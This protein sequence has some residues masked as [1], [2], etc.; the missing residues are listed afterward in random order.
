VDIGLFVFVPFG[1]VMISVDANRDVADADAI[2]DDGANSI[3]FSNVLLI[4]MSVADGSAGGGG[5]GRGVGGKST[6]VNDDV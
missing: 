4:E 6:V 3:G 2:A 1:M 5:G